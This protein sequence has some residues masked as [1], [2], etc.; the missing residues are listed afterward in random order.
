MKNSNPAKKATMPQVAYF[1]MIK[2]SSTR[3][4]FAALERVVNLDERILRVVT[5]ADHQ[6]PTRIRR[7]RKAANPRNAPPLGFSITPAA[8]TASTQI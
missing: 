3:T 6:L 8:T 2:P 4:Y 5:I 1:Q 7:Q